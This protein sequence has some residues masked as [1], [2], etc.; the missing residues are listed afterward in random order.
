MKNISRRDTIQL[1]GGGIIYFSLFQREVLGGSLLETQEITQKQWFDELFSRKEAIGGLHLY[2]FHDEIYG[3]TK[4][5]SWIPD[6]KWS[7]VLP[8]I[9]VPTGFITDFASVP[10]IFWSILP[11]DGKYTY[12]AILHDY[13]YWSQTLSRKEADEIFRIGMK[14]FG[15]SDTIVNAIY[16]SIRAVGG[17]AWDANT[18]LKKKGEKRVVKKFPDDPLMKWS[19]WKKNPSVFK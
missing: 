9:D 10:R 2:R 12:P 17:F 14:E 4:P 8:K 15:I 3:L 7:E 19:D 16:W 5:I 13:L 6:K 18:E 11:R 1:L